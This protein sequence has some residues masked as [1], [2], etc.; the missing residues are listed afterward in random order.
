VK[1][2]ELN[3]VQVSYLKEDL[4]PAFHLQ[5]VK[6]VEFNHVKAQHAANVPTFVLNSV[7]NLM[8][9]ASPGIPDIKLKSA[10]RK[11]F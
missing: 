5:D 9:Q 2:I 1:G 10:D 3:D 6:D 4:R 8:V 7:E 11:E